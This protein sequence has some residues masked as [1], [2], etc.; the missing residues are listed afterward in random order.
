MNDTVSILNDLLA[1][2]ESSPVEHL[3]RSGYF[4]SAASY[5]EEEAV[6]RMHR[7]G[8]EH[9][10]WLVQAIERRAG[11][12]RPRPVDVSAAGIHY[13][14][15]HYML[16]RVLANYEGIVQRYRAASGR[17]SGDADAAGLVSR[18]LRRHEEHLAALRKLTEAK[19]SAPL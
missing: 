11:S 8:Q 4:V 12:V 14:D 10:S 6:R 3:L 13:T 2:E 7:E 18:I 1:A 19:S 5:Q 9:V 17:L 16:P 15:L